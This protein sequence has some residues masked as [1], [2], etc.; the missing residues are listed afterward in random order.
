MPSISA[1][2]AN[3]A[4]ETPLAKRLS[5]RYPEAAVLT[6]LPVSTLQ[7]LVADGTLRS[8]KVGRARLIHTKSLIALLEGRASTRSRRAGARP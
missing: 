4:R 1:R 8:M 6:G 3:L 5:V 7:A 2:Q